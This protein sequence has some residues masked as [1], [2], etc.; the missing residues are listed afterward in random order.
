MSSNEIEFEMNY[1]SGDM[2]ASEKSLFK[3]NI[4]IQFK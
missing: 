4:T 3:S 1:V 2:N